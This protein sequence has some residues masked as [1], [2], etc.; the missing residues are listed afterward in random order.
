M[1]DVDNFPCLINTWNV[2]YEKNNCYFHFHYKNQ[3]FHLKIDIVNT[4]SI[5]FKD[6]RYDKTKF[7][8]GNSIKSV[9]YIFLLKFH[10]KINSN[11]FT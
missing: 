1:R 4:S 2:S 11:F 10:Q 5:L 8:W 6:E 7:C 9:K 3:M